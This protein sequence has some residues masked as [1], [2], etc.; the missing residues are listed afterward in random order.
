MPLLVTI[1]AQRRAIIAVFV[2]AGVVCQLRWGLPPLC[3][4]CRRCRYDDAVGAKGDVR[5]VLAK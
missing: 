5:P 1:I 3:D 2:L 4:D